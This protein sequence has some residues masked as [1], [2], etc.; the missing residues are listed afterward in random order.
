MEPLE[1][2]AG[3]AWEDQRSEENRLLHPT[4]PRE[5]EFIKEG[6]MEAANAGPIE[7]YPDAD[8][9]TPSLSVERR[10]GE[11]TDIALRVAAGNAVRAAVKDAQ[12]VLLAPLM[13]VEVS[14]PE[15][16]TGSV[17]GDLSA[18][19]ARIEGVNTEAGRGVVRAVSTNRVLGPLH[20]PALD[21]R[22]AR[23]L[24]HALCAV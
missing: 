24:L 15:A 21:E 9:E 23:D 1:R 14:V 2:G 6:A 20:A 7:G 13:S 8:L 17:V 22:G 19:G 4:S 16:V 18:R 3:M 11:T 5:F 12:P 10:P